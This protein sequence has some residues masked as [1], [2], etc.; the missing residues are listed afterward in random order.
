MCIEEILIWEIKNGNNKMVIE[1]TGRYSY[2][3][4]C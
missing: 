4:L 2:M 1:I 3:L